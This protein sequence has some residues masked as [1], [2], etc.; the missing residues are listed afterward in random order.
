VKAPVPPS[1]P[2]Y[3]RETLPPQAGEE[4]FDPHLPFPP[5]FTGEVPPKAAEG[6]LSSIVARAA[7]SLRDAGIE[8]PRME[9]RILLAHASKASVE[10]IIAERIAL[11]P[12][13]LARFEVALSRR[14]A[15]EPIGYITGRREFWSLNFIVDQN[16]LIPRPETEVLVEEALRRFPDSSAPLSVLD[17]GTGSGCILLAFL[18]ERPNATGVGIDASPGAAAIAARN[19]QALK[20]DA[21]AHFSVQDWS[22]VSG[23]YDLVFSNPPYIDTADIASLA[24]DVAAYEPFEALDGGKDGFD[25]YRSLALL[26]PKVM[27]SGGRAFIELGQGQAD[28]AAR[29]FRGQGLVIDAL[30]NDLAQIPRC[31]VLSR[32][33]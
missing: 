13:A 32:Q 14:I 28:T 29:I 20:L 4:K 22:E 9:A 8:N 31:L 7:A 1:S 30:V 5:P 27:K 19:A 15:R 11:T 26:L 12:D 3:S 17:L 2:A 18:S 23:A 21:R 6:G 10:D 25:A 16:V 33:T 24:P